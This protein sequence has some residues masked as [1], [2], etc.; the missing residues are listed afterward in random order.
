MKQNKNLFNIFYDKEADVLY[1]SQDKPSSRDLTSET[2]EEMVVR[3]N[4]K[5]EIKGFTI[6]HFLKRGLNKSSL[7][8]LPF[9]LALK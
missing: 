5:G 7:I 8:P 4:S 3:R 1:I 2:E 6:L 9:Q